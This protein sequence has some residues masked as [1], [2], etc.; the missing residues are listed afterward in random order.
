MGLSRN[1]IGPLSV[2]TLYQEEEAIFF[3]TSEPPDIDPADTDISYTVKISDRLDLLASRYL[4]SEQRGWIILH[5]NNLR[6]APND[7]VPGQKIFI[8]TLESL[9]ER[10]ITG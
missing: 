5:R 1:P 9:R 6:L 3:G 7:L 8:P 10:G 2:N 4:A